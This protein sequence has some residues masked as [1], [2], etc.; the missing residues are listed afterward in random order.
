ML[1]GMGLAGSSGGIQSRAGTQPRLWRSQSLGRSESELPPATHRGSRRRIA[2]GRRAGSHVTHDFGGPVGAIFIALASF[3]RCDPDSSKSA[4]E[5]KRSKSAF[6][7]IG[8]STGGPRPIP[9]KLTTTLQKLGSSM[10]APTPSSLAVAR[11][12]AL[13]GNAPRRVSSEE[14]GSQV[15]ARR[16]NCEASSRTFTWRSES[17]IKAIAWL[18]R[19]P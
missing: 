14:D 16:L 11:M 18:R 1:R 10:E 3:R 8:R 19:W 6:V 17:T 2:Q 7:A 12:Q 13:M 9:E 15:S 4:F 5:R